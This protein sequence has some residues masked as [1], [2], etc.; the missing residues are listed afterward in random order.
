MVWQS[1]FTPSPNQDSFACFPVAIPYHNYSDSTKLES[2][3]IKGSHQQL[4]AGT[5]SDLNHTLYVL[6]L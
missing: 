3:N 1:A 2:A 4:F 6:L 5:F